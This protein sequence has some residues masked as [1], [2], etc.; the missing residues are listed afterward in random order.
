[1]ARKRITLHENDPT[2]FVRARS[3]EPGAFRN[4][5]SY[6]SRSSADFRAR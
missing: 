5:L 4:I 1:V 2:K 6:F 3:I